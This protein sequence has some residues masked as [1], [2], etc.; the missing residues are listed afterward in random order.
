MSRVKY[1]GIV[2]Y[3]LQEVA[4]S[5]VEGLVSVAMEAKFG[6]L[7]DKIVDSGAR[8]NSTF[9]AKIIDYLSTPPLPAGRKGPAAQSE[10][11]DAP[12]AIAAGAPPTMLPVILDSHSQGEVIDYRPQ[13][14][15]PQTPFRESIPG[16]GGPVATSIA[17]A[18]YGLLI[19]HNT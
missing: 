19:M 15:G 3:N 16:L 2:D 4:K 14:F 12:T 7:R 17:F 1:A 13:G 8:V 6:V 18:S 9:A 11:K 5:G 10:Q